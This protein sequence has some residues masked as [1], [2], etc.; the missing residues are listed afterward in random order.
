VTVRVGTAIVL[1]LA[2]ATL[3]PANASPSP[4]VGTR[5]ATAVVSDASPGARPVALTIRLHTELQCGR[6]DAT[7]ITVSLPQSMRVPAAVSKTAVTVAGKPATSV[8]TNGTR[9]L[10]HTAA[11]KAGVTCDVIAPGVVAIK[12]TRLAGLGNPLRA[13]SYAFGVV[14]GPGGG[15]WHGVLS[16]H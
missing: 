8:A 12:F 16:I 6:F 4:D 14:T 13:G 11:P 3:M 15:S 1:A 10:I 2:A 9:V 5:G 7:S